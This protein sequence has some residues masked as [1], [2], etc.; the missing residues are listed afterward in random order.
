MSYLVFCRIFSSIRSLPKNQPP[1]KYTVPDNWLNT[2]LGY[3][4]CKVSNTEFSEVCRI[5]RRVMF[6]SVDRLRTQR[7][8]QTASVGQQENTEYDDETRDVLVEN[9]SKNLQVYTHHSAAKKQVT[10]ER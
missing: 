8:E 5:R 2:F 1:S 4:R 3:L 6:E 10:N 9:A 7:Q